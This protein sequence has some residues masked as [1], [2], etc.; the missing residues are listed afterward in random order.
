MK[1]FVRPNRAPSNKCAVAAIMDNP[2]AVV[3][4]DESGSQ[5]VVSPKMART[6]ADQ[7]LDMASIA[8]AKSPPT[9]RMGLFQSP[10]SYLH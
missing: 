5:I 6:L 3:V 9:V 10:G 2:P 7:L 1:K 4:Q 8:E